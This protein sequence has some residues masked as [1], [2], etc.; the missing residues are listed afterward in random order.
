MEPSLYLELVRDN[1]A[2]FAGRV[3]NNLNGTNNTNINSGYRH[4]T[5]LNKIFSATLKW[6]SVTNSNNIAVAADIIAMDSEIPLK[7]RGTLGGAQGDV[8]KLAMKKWLNERQMAD[9][10]IIARTPGQTNQLISLLFQDTPMVIKGVFEKLEYMFLEGLST[11]F[12]T[13]TDPENIGLGVRVNYNFNATQTVFDE[14]ANNPTTATPLT[15]MQAAQATANAAGYSIIRWMMDRATFNAMIA[16]NQVKQEVAAAL[17]FFGSNIPG[18]TF[19][20]VNN[21][22]QDKYGWSI[23]I[24]E[25]RVVT[26]KDGV[27]T[28]RVPWAAG[29][30][31]G[32]ST[33]IVGSLTWSRCVEMDHP[34]GGVTYST[35]QDYI[36]ASKYRKNEP[37]I[38]EWTSSQAMVIP[39]I[40]ST[41][42]YIIDTT[43]A[44]A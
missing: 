7:T 16:T 40:D 44:T 26:E 43:T 37:S 1:F 21:A 12:T 35:V 15:D 13:M 23:E 6:Q 33:P 20:Q 14:W 38:S 5:M 22:L 9:L 4:L 2:T 11:G 29:Q 36:L 3:V 18:V 25:R 28:V 8:P 39:V 24:V 41:G 32:I 19:S 42:I 31:V 27:Q 17:G 10:G 30:V 34:V